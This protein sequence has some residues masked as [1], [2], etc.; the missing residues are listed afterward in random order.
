MK[1]KMV[2]GNTWCNPT[3]HTVF[4]R[5]HKHITH[6]Q[7]TRAKH[8]NKS[9]F[10]CVCTKSNSNQNPALFIIITQRIFHKQNI[11][12]ATF[13]KVKS[14]I[15]IQYTEIQPLNPC[16]MHFICKSLTP[17]LAKLIEGYF[18]DYSCCANC[19]HLKH[20]IAII[21]IIEDL[22]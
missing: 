17:T 10:L 21:I 9:L 19:F 20:F 5:V 4:I 8:G 3:C 2:R 6:K 13:T 16:I 22:E 1:P 14:M 12:N 7:N 18:E 15:R 11:Q